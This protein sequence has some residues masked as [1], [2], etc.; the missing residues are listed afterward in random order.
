[1]AQFKRTPTTIGFKGMHFLKFKMT[2]EGGVEGGGGEE[3][4]F[5]KDGRV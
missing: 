1:M 5:V 2:G 4:V 3:V